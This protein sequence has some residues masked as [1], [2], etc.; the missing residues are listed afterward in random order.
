MCAG[1]SEINQRTQPICILLCSN[2]MNKDMF[3]MKYFCS[4]KSF[5]VVSVDF[6]EVLRLSRSCHKYDRSQCDRSQYEHS[7]YENSI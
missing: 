3:H 7:Q 2:G 6:M 1:W 4:N 5:V